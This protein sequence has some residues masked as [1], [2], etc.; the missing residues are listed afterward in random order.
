MDKVSPTCN[1]RCWSPESRESPVDQPG[2]SE[3]S[4]RRRG[5]RL[6]GLVETQGPSLWPE[7]QALPHALQAAMA[8]PRAAGNGAATG[9]RHP[10]PCR[11]S[12]V[13]QG[14]EQ[15]GSWW[16]HSQEPE[17]RSNS[18]PV[19]HSRAANGGGVFTE[20]TRADGAGARAL[21]RGQTRRGVGGGQ[22][23]AGKPA[24]GTAWP[25]QETEGYP[26][27]RGP[28]AAERSEP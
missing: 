5:A 15:E 7:A 9:R 13:P 11:R 8:C 3:E 14:A 19:G 16:P 23:Q 24:G 27:R 6:P 26:G 17:I 28:R 21:S 22:V 25:L 1:L 20:R 4:A 2:S 18:G 12:P 10:G